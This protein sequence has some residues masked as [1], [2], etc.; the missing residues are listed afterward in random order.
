MSPAPTASAI[1]PLRHALP[2]EESDS[3][4]VRLRKQWAI[5][6]VDDPTPRDWRRFELCS[7]RALFAH[8]ETRIQRVDA[9]G[10]FF[11]VIG[12]VIDTVAPHAGVEG[13]LRAADAGSASGIVEV[14]RDWTGTYALIA[15][16]SSD[17]WVYTDAASLETVY[18][19]QGRAAST[20][21]LLPGLTRDHELDSQF[22]LNAV[23]DWY[24]GSICPFARTQALLANHRL[25]VRQ[26]RTERFWPDY[27]PRPVDRAAAVDQIGSLLRAAVVG[28]HRQSPVLASLTGGKDTRLCLAASRDVVQSVEFFT[29]RAPG[30]RTCDLDIADSI[31]KRFRLN[32]RFVDNEPAPRWLLALYDEMSAGMSVGGRRDIIGACRLLASDHYVHLNGNLGAI[33]K[34]F[35]WPSNNPR[36]VSMA[37]VQ[38]SF[39]SRKPCIY[40]G[41]LEWR[42]TVPELSPAATYNLMYLEQ[43][44]GRWEGVGENASKLF[45]GSMSPFCNRRVFEL[46]CGVPPAEQ[47]HQL[48]IDIVRRLWPDL[49][50][51]PYCRPTTRWTRIVPKGLRARARALLPR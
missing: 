3:E 24:P 34:R 5:L 43:R 42:S 19:G 45:Y 49:L 2:L 22:R 20:P 32:H 15:C 30:V 14:L 46:V 33:A 47:G 11:L 18:F 28:L 50:E 12:V 51:I 1:P 40:Q 13:R 38:R 37:R 17:T 31:A 23:D 35:F 39:S 44:G 16:S 27:D 4:S 36:H 9:S 7:K 41:L 29:I 21:S 48:L 25:D 26:G 10:G 6:L 8:P